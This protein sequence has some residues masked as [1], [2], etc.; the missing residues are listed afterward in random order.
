MNESLLEEKPLAAKIEEVLRETNKAGVD[1]VRWELVKEEVKLITFRY[2]QEKAAQT[3]AE[4]RTLELT[5]KTLIG[6]ESRT[7]GVFTSDIRE[8]K[9]RLL[10]IMEGE[11]RGA[12]VRCRLH[13]L[14]TE[15]KPVKIFKT[16][17]RN[18]IRR[19][20]ITSLQVGEQVFSEQDDIERELVDTFTKL[21]SVQKEVDETTLEKCLEA[22]PKIPPEISEKINGEITEKEIGEAIKELNTRKSPGVDGLGSAFYKKFSS[23]LIPILRNV[24]ADI[25]KRNLL[26]PSMRQAVTVLIP[27]KN[28]GSSVTSADNLRPISLLTSDYKI[29][30]KILTKRIEQGLSCIV[31]NHQPYGFKGR[32]ITT[33][34]HIMRTICETAEAE[35]HPI[36]V[37]QVD[38]SKA[39]DRVSH[40]FLFTLLE[41]CSLG[42]TL[43]KYIKIC[44]REITTRLLVNGNQ[45]TP[46]KVKSSVRQGCPMSPLLFALYLEPLCKII[47]ADENIQGVNLGTGPTKILAY[48]DDVAIV[49]SS[50]RELELAVK[51][52]SDFSNASGAVMNMSKSTGAWLGPW[53]TKPERYLGMNWSC[54]VSKYLGIELETLSLSTGREGIHLNKVHGKMSE[55][56]GRYLSFFNRSFVCNSVFFS[57]VWYAAQVVP[58]RQVD[59]HKFHRICA[60]F[61]WQSLFERMRRTNLFLS[62]SKG[63]M[64]LVNLELK[65]KVNRFLFFRDQIHPVLARSLKCLGGRYLSAWQVSTEEA[66]R[67]APVLRFYKEI[68]DAITFFQSRFSWDYLIQANRKKLYWDTIDLVIP[69]PMYR[70]PPESVEGSTVFKKLRKYPVKTCIKDFFVK[71][72]TEVLPVKT[73]LENKG[74][75][76]AGSVNCALCPFQETLHH[77]FLYCTNAEIFWSEL[78]HALNLD[79]AQPDWGTLKFLRVAA[80][81]NQKCVEVLF[82]LGMH[83]IWRSRTDHTLVEEKGK[84][85]WSHFVEGFSYTS[86]L[87][88][89]TCMPGFEQWS[90][91]QARLKNYM[92]KR[93]KFINRNCIMLN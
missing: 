64:G 78:R 9:S 18:H 74:F 10:S 36:A 30:A 38:L 33:N 91:M 15:E 32:S 62:L 42:G 37:L 85:A 76:L 80:G 12:M 77:V 49:C 63:G 70:S 24:Y 52:L 55:W 71:F 20:K 88:E 56:H 16:K 22:M 41:R 5:L 93:D 45:T 51:H 13:A 72:H 73:W 6:E 57:S 29:L 2:S 59:I 14:D 28:A 66:S 79:E 54:S 81:V 84:P 48:A 35:Q 83:A 82:L 69:P 31:G 67:R 19:N 58:S 89:Q 8:C 92:V 11:Y 23:L 40:S 21:L 39:F 50:K 75:L 47:M 44:Y 61:I 68:E 53:I 4:K 90:V 1:A 43:T 27:K 17:E 86:N 26:P 60:T 65:I 3:R 87:L 7:P 34:S 46:I 25:L